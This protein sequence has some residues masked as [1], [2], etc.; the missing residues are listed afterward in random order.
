MGYLPQSQALR[1]KYLPSGY[2]T[3]RIQ[4]DFET[5][6]GCEGRSAAYLLYVVELR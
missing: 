6:D 5:F 1:A 3:R 2:C 4:N